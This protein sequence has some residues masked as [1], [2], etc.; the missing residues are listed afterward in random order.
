[1]NGGTVHATNITP[2]RLIQEHPTY[3]SAVEAH[4][5]GGFSVLPTRWPRAA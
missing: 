5:E 4:L 2:V 3:V 1:M